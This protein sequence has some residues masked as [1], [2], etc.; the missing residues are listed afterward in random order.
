M[1]FNK[2]TKKDCYAVKITAVE[3]NQE[4][5]RAYLYIL[6]NDLHAEPFGLLEDVFVAENQRGNGLGSKLVQMAIEE[7]KKIGCY[8]LVA[9][10]R[11]TK[12]V[13]C[14][15]YE[16]FGFKNHGVEFRMELL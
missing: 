10:V 15:W 14:A 8:K 7:A 12:G 11:N 6:Y 2:E 13:V 1:N 4:I 3:D 9:T 5:G 16:K